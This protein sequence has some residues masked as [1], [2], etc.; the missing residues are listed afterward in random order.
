MAASTEQGFFARRAAARD[1]ASRRANWESLRKPANQDRPPLFGQP[2]VGPALPHPEEGGQGGA[3]PQRA[4]RGGWVWP[5]LGAGG[6]VI[7]LVGG[8]P[9]V[10][11]TWS[12]SWVVAAGVVALGAAAQSLRA[13]NHGARRPVAFAGVGGALMVLACVVGL[14]TQVVVDGQAQLDTSETAAAVRLTDEARAALEVLRGNQALLGLPV[15]QATALLGL[16]D[17]AIRQDLRLAERWNPATAGEL[18]GEGF[19]AVHI[20]LNRAAVRQADAL[21][22]FSL[23]VKSPADSIAAELARL[24]ALLDAQ[25][26][27]GT[28]IEALIDDAYRRSTLSPGR[29]DT[30]PTNGEDGK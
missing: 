20:E 8:T 5:L 13:W 16:Y 17:D 7:A 11:G 9:A 28:G 22:G 26:A 15:E 25:L 2:T 14:A 27:P 10:S 12:W 21:A 3:P 29:A 19:E 24:R 1:A 18:P 23:N 30:G 6:V 4:P